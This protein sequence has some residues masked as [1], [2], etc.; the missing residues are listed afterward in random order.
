MKKILIVCFLSFVTHFYGQDAVTKMENVKHN[1][2]TLRPYVLYDSG[3]KD[4]E[5]LKYFRATDTKTSILVFHSISSKDSIQIVS[6]GKVI[7]EELFFPES[8]TGVR[9]I[10]PISNQK[11]L[12]ILFYKK[13][14]VEKIDI[15]AEDL[16]KYKFIYVSPKQRPMEVEYTNIWKQFM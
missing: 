11:G 5:Y 7:K 8:T 3:K 4:L 14:G 2:I 15:S 10:Q 16:K 12:E 6:G 1:Y 13:T 9:S